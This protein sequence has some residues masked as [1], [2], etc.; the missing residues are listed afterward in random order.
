MRTL[1]QSFQYRI[2]IHTVI[3]VSFVVYLLRAIGNEKYQKKSQRKN[4]SDAHFE[5]FILELKAYV[6]YA[7]H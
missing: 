2:E 3:L 1:F 4:I 6:L 7:D 5:Q